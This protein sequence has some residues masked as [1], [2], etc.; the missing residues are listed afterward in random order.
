MKQPMPCASHQPAVG[1]VRVA[2][3]LEHG[4]AGAGHVAHRAALEREAALVVAEREVHAGGHPQLPG[5]RVE[6]R[7]QGLAR[8]GHAG[9][10]VD[11]AAV[12]LVGLERARHRLGGALEPELVAGPRGLRLEERGPLHGHRRE[13]GHHL[14]APEV[15]AAE[16]L[17]G[18]ERG[19]Q[20]HSERLSH[21]VA[22]APGD[23]RGSA[24]GGP[25]LA[26]ALLA[27]RLPPARPGG[28]ARPPRPRRAEAAAAGHARGRPP[29]A[30]AARARA[31][32]RSS[33]CSASLSS[34]VANQPGG[35]GE[36][37]ALLVHRH[38]GHGV[39]AQERPHVL[40]EAGGGALGPAIRLSAGRGRWEG[41]G[42]HGLPA[43]PRAPARQ[44]L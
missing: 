11:H 1:P 14:D 31:A 6:P 22:Q 3:A 37:A 5:A 8:P 20:D 40:D 42:C 28:R 29:P 15:G 9:G 4:R 44:S 27:E 26:G 36:Q 18:I 35:A 21:G 38:E 24:E 25:H 30:R 34:G 33:G 43:L 39:H 12:H 17:R 2:A 19:Q 23:H 10:V 7:E 13:V 16:R 32:A 41:A